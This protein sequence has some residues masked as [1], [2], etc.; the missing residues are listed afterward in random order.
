MKWNEETNEKLKNLINS[1]KRHDEIA[2]FFG[3]SKKTISN[4][5]FRLKLKIKLF[6]TI[7]CKS[8][9]KK[10]VKLIKSPQ[11]FCSNS[12]SAKY[13]NSLRTHSVQTKNKISN[14]LLN[15]NN[16]KNK[17][18]LLISKKKVVRNCRNCNNILNE[19]RK[20]ICNT[21]RINYYKFYRPSCEFKFNVFDFQDE[22]NIQLLI[23]NGFY[24]PTN[25][26]NN[27]NGVSKDH[28]FSVCDG[29]K[30]KIPPEIISHPA[31]CELL[32]HTDNNKKK[33]KSSITIDELYDKIEKWDKKYR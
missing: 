19:P 21:C 30:N 23:T 7:Q 24:S 32:I 16:N 8:C 11:K 15:N 25:K 10:V 4:K 9:E 18:T 26:K 1:G 29:F 17:N 28:K 6:E 14:A 31:N 20:I 5:C 33:I 22:Y 13:S 3:V 2:T 12:C 27:L